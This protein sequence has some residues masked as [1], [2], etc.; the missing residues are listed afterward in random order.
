MVLKTASL[1]A[2]RAVVQ[3]N[4]ALLAALACLSTVVKFLTLAENDC[5]SNEYLPSTSIMPRALGCSE[6]LNVRFFHPTSG[7]T[8]RT[9]VV[10]SEREI[11]LRR[12]GCDRDGTLYPESEAEGLT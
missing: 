7:V 6:E 8:S 11:R 3:P 1:C 4:K 12:R 5:K 9:F 10:L 2:W